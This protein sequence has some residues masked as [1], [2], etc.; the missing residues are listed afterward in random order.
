MEE[1]LK[2]ELHHVGVHPDVLDQVE[3]ALFLEPLEYFKSLFIHLIF[4]LPL[5]N[6]GSGLVQLDLSDRELDQL[7]DLLPGGLIT[8]DDILLHLLELVPP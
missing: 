3:V 2:L 4:C 5:E 8:H 1:L 7:F 6:R